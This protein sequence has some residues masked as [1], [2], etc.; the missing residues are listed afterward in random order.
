MVTISQYYYHHNWREKNKGWNGWSPLWGRAFR[1]WPPRQGCWHGSRIWSMMQ[2]LMFDTIRYD[3]IQYDTIW[4]LRIWKP[5]P[6]RWAL[7]FIFSGVSHVSVLFDEDDYHHRFPFESLFSSSSSSW[8]SLLH[9]FHLPDPSFRAIDLRIAPSR[10]PLGQRWYQC[11]WSM[12]A[13]WGKW[14][15]FNHGGSNDANQNNE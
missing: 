14:T 11:L 3:A 12:V 9:S 7:M 15:I 10:S 1:P 4:M 2:N 5:Y 13:P 8:S 6:V